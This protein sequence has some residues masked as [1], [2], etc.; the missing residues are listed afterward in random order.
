ME[1]I[2]AFIVLVICG[3]ILYKL[4]YF[5]IKRVL[6]LKS[7]YSLKKQCNANITLHN[8]FLRP[9]WWKSKVPD[10]TVQIRDTVYRLH[11]YSGGG[12]T[13]YV[14]FANERFSVVYSKWKTVMR[15]SRGVHGLP[16]NLGLT[17]SVKGRVNVIPP[18]SP[19]ESKG[20]CV[21]VLLFSP[22]PAEVSYV[23]EEKTSI[24]LAFTGD[25]F[26][27]Y[28]IFTPSTFAV[29]AERQWRAESEEY[30]RYY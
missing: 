12:G 25:S 29:F 11:L 6:M 14:H 21:N 10:I 22:A 4:T 27:G 3:I 19:H 16:R 9:M 18:I 28:R 24:R 17:L 1:D 30:T 7:I 8:F 2:I 15:S 23:T 13:K 5:I 20:R 26:Y